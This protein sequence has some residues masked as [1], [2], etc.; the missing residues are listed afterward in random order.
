MITAEDAIV[1]VREVTDEEVATF[2]EKGWVKLP[3]FIEPVTAG[4]L[5][6]RVKRWMG[7]AGDQ[8]K[9]RPGVDLAL[10]W[11]QQYKDPSRED[12]L[13]RALVNASGFG[14]ATARLLGRDAAVRFFSDG[15][16]AKLPASKGS[17]RG[18][19]TDFHQDLRVIPVDQVTLG[20][21]FALDEVTPD[22]GSLRFYEGSH[23]LGPLGPISAA[24]L[25][26]W[27]QLA[28]CPLSEPNHLL[29]GDVTAHS[30][31]TV[32]GAGANESDRP[33]WGYYSGYCFA[34]AS[35]TN[36]PNQYTN[37]LGLEPFKPLEH[38]RFPIVYEP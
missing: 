22:Q 28:D 34:D 26:S 16:L 32:H 23:K 27:Q 29:P 14:R 1:A 3:Q 36:L 19:P 21:W 9:D 12:D 30:G 38:E 20:F 4:D 37:D 25:A 2:Q 24:S 35:Y 10:S 17:G 5:L 18:E 7:A 11:F 15:V 33:R 31:L 6:A 13:F 8:H